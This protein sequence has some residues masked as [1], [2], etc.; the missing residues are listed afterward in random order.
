MTKDAQAVFNEFNGNIEVMSEALAKLR[1]GAEDLIGATRIP[2][3]SSDT[4]SQEA[5]WVLRLKLAL[6]ESRING[7]TSALDGS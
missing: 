4:S 1:K 5:V 7:N 3:D 6:A 2:P